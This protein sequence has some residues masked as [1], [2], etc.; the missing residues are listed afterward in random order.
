MQTPIGQANKVIEDWAKV[1][2]KCQQKRHP[3]RI[4]F[5][6]EDSLSLPTDINIYDDPD[7]LQEIQKVYEQDLDRENN[8][9]LVNDTLQYLEN[10]HKAK[11]NKNVDRRASKNR[12]IRYHVHPQLLNF[13]PTQN[14][15]FLETRDE[16]VK[17]LFNRGHRD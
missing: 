3:I 11:A 10:R 14:D 9:F 17:N 5:E 2:K 7:L 16:I 15:H 8:D 6:A 12:K 13:V 4:L 1:S